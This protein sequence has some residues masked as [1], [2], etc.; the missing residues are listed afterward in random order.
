MLSLN[1][2]REIIVYILFIC[3]NLTFVLKIT[4]LGTTPG[5]IAICILPFL[6]LNYRKQKLSILIFFSFLLIL[7]P[8]NSYGVS[9]IIFYI[10][11]AYSVRDISMQTIL[12]ANILSQIVLSFICVAL[13]K[14]GI[15]SD[16]IIT[17]PYGMAHDFGY[18]N[19]NTLAQYY[20]YFI[21]S[22]Y[23]IWF[24]RHPMLLKYI[25]LTLSVIMFYYTQARSIILVISLLF[26]LLYIPI[27]NIK[28]IITSRFVILITICLIPLFFYLLTLNSLSEYLNEVTSRRS[29]FLLSVIN[30]L[31]I[32]NL[33]Y[34]ME[35]PEGLIIDNVFMLL[36]L[37]GGIG[38]LAFVLF[39]FYHI[40]TK[41]CYPIQFLII[42]FSIFIYGFTESCFLNPFISG[43]YIF[44]ILLI[45]NKSI[46]IKH[47]GSC[48]LHN[49]Q[50]RIISSAEKY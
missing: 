40:M 25:M 5:I 26:I 13:L 32:P 41:D 33:I 37:F 6:L 16:Y 17:K 12:R 43:T 23:L 19:A 39:R 20:I 31:S 18:G 34:G 27:K 38:T 30:E 15:I 47:E 42:I 48:N 4:Q 50:S 3:I 24:D 10:L 2:F 44:W 11:V 36:I 45:G 1:K 7:L 9:N 28:L 49:V 14:F 29:F 35:T 21:I 46:M 22:I 8:Y